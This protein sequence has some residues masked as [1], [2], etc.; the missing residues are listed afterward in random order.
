MRRD[1][2]EDLGP[3][4]EPRAS[5]SRGADGTRVQS[6]RYFSSLHNSAVV[7]RTC[8]APQVFSMEKISR[9]DLRPVLPP[10]TC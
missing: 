2:P 9:V 1:T 5:V 7:F 8:V 6:G 4:V 10:H 3:P